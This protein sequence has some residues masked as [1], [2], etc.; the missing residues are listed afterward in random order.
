MLWGVKVQYSREERTCLRRGAEKKEGRWKCP[1][2][3]ARGQTVADSAETGHLTCCSHGP[4]VCV[5]TTA[6]GF[7]PKKPNRKKKKTL[8][9]AHDVYSH[10]PPTSIDIMTDQVSN[11]P[12]L[13][14]KVLQKGPQCGR[15][16]PCA[17]LCTEKEWQNVLPSHPSQSID[18]F[19]TILLRSQI[20]KYSC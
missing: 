7:H 2:L 20:M 5:P 1:R 13:A 9:S 4:P 3:A 6:P 11:P 16:P 12:K 19:S 18:W 10:Q 14:L 17:C 8:S 15:C